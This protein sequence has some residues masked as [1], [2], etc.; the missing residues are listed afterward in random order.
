MTGSL[1]DALKEAAIAGFVE[2]E[3]ETAVTVY[4]DF[5]PRQGDASW[6][7][8]LLLRQGNHHTITRNSS[9]NQ[10]SRGVTL[11]THT[12]MHFSVGLL[13]PPHVC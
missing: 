6:S 13:P 7:C 3:A 2:G 8:P 10:R 9:S 1:Q 12:A 4:Y 5:V 11:A